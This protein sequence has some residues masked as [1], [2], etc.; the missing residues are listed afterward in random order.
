MKNQKHALQ[1]FVRKRVS[2]FRSMHSFSQEQMA[3]MLHIN[4][5]SYLDQEHGKYGF[6]AMSL[7]FFLLL[8]SEN[9]LIKFFSE[10]R[11]VLE[12]SDEDAA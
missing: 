8:L 1:S 12:R 11:I 5:R 6:S 2:S 10:L 3:E 4:A 9:D 7:V